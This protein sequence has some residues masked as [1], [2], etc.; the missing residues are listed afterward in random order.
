M[1]SFQFFRRFSRAGIE[2]SLR[3]KGR[4]DVKLKKKGFVPIVLPS[5]QPRRSFLP[6]LPFT[7]SSLPFILSVFFASSNGITSDKWLCSNIGIG[8]RSA[9]SLQLD[10][11]VPPFLSSPSLNA[12]SETLSIYPLDHRDVLLPLKGGDDLPPGRHR[13]LHQSHPT[14]RI[15]P[16]WSHLPPRQTS[17]PQPYQPRYLRTS[18]LPRRLHDIV[19]IPDRLSLFERNVEKRRKGDRKSIHPL[20]Q[21]NREGAARLRAMGGRD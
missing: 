9:F 5:F 2:E 12:D 3:R 11:S 7:S 13:S 16:L 17:H 15:R 8:R 10:A 20:G 6:S 19:E 1:S 4:A 21:Q 18:A 14:S